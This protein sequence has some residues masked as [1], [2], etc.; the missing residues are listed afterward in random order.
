M[1]LRLCPSVVVGEICRPL[2]SRR[3]LDHCP[4]TKQDQA[5]SGAMSGR[6]SNSFRLSS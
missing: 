3:C 4:I 6:W 1:S 2:I 5:R